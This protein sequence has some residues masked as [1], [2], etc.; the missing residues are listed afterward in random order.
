MI[1]KYNLTQS[2]DYIET[3]TYFGGEDYL[4]EKFPMMYE[5]IRKGHER[6]ANAAAV[7]DENGDVIGR[8]DILTVNLAIPPHGN[9]ANDEQPLMELHSHYNYTEKNP[10]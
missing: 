1:K 9:A 10:P 8:K 5:A 7:P 6:N 4:K 2:S 3:L